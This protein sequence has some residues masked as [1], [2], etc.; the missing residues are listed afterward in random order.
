MNIKQ[1]RNIHLYLGVFFAPLLVFYLIS[2]AWQTFGLHVPSRDGTYKPP[3][4]IKSLSQVHKNQRW[5]D[6]RKVPKSSVPFRY[7]VLL[8]VV[9]LLTTTVL[10]IMMAFKYTK[11]WVVWVCLVLGTA[12]PIILL[13]LARL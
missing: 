7:L 3:A 6:S 10:G 13:W 5:V 4:I 8:M 11:P 2:G 1:M 12:I 9:G